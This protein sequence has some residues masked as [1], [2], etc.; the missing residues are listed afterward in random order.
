LLQQGMIII[1]VH[2]G[3]I[4]FGLRCGIV[5][6]FDFFGSF[7]GGFC[8]KLSYASVT[9]VDSSLYQGFHFAV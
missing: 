2:G 7:P 4:L 6:L 5:C 9:H 3:A 1:L 8:H